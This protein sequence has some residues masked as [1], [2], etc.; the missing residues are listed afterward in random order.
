MEEEN[1]AFASVQRKAEPT[2]GIRAQEHEPLLKMNREYVV[3]LPL[4]CFLGIINRIVDSVLPSLFTA[5]DTTVEAE[6]NAVKRTPKSGVPA[7]ALDAFGM[8]GPECAAFVKQERLNHL[9]IEETISEILQYWMKSLHDHLLHAKEWDGDAVATFTQTIVDIN[10]HWTQ[11]T[12][13]RLLPKHHMLRHCVEFASKHQYLGRYSEAP[14]EAV[15]A[16]WNVLQE[17]N[18]RHKGSNMEA[19]LKGVLQLF[20]FAGI[21]FQQFAECGML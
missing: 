19:K 2:I 15:H 21:A 7:G 1:V 5:D 10:Q 16:R 17:K 20:A 8:N 3:P 13:E 4:H 14:M 6:K 18:F 9:Q 11:V 12:G